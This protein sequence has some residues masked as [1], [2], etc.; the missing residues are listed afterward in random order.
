MQPQDAGAGAH[1][2]TSARPLARASALCVR[3]C[4]EVLV[5]CNTLGELA[6]GA[7]EGGGRAAAAAGDPQL[8]YHRSMQQALAAVVEREREES[9]EEVQGEE[10]GSLGGGGVEAVAVG[11]LHRELVAQLLSSATPAAV[12]A[13]PPCLPLGAPVVLQLGL[14]AVAA[15]SA[16][17]PRPRRVRVLLVSR[18]AVLLDT[19][20]GVAQG[21]TMLR[22]VQRR[23]KQIM[24]QVV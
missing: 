3:G 9:G 11:G 4:I 16:G 12:W 10:A 24:V 18:G 23:L 15:A 21:Q 19:T 20:L 5:W 14:P 2:A 1:A 22:W 13:D 6:P 8:Y 17:S 7:V